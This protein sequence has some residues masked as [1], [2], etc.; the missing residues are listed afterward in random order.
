MPT[1]IRKS[2]L[3]QSELKDLATGIL[4]F[5]HEW[6]GE[7]GRDMLAKT[8]AGSQSKRLPYRLK[9]S[10]WYSQYGHC[11]KK[12]ILQVIDKLESDYYLY[13]T[14]RFYPTL[15]LSKKALRVLSGNYSLP[16]INIEGTPPRRR[17]EKATR[18][19][20]GS[21]IVSG[22]DKPTVL[23]DTLFQTWDLYTKGMSLG[24]IARVRQLKESTIVEHLSRLA[25]AGE[26]IDVER[27]IPKE[28]IKTIQDTIRKTNSSSLKVIKDTLSENSPDVDEYSYSNIK[29]VM[30]CPSARTET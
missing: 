19:S 22:K 15:I 10:D 7:F 30:Y 27:F 13:R 26:T 21:T 25:Q 20:I 24:E 11:S 12:S 2:Q 23:S 5:V 6:D 1:K 28:R 18:R 3:T 14:Q 4:K 8:L 17:L 9:T 29:L 16:T